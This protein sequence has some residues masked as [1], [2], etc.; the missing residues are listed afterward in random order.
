MQRNH[1]ADGLR[2]TGV[3]T[4]T[5]S[6][7][8]ARMRWEG[9]RTAAGTRRQ[10]AHLLQPL[11]GVPGL[12]QLGAAHACQS[13]CKRLRPGCQTSSLGCQTLHLGLLSGNGIL[14]LRQLGLGCLGHL[15]GASWAAA[16][17]GSQV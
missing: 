11:D 3:A 9:A 14:Q 15:Q 6:E 7:V 1:A 2:Y 12:A 17:D 16:E 5:S 4:R 10:A 8:T 13:L